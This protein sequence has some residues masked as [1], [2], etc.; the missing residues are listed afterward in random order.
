MN[1]GID[2]VG[3][4]SVNVKD[5]F[6]GTL[7]RKVMNHVIPYQWEI[8]NDRVDDAPK[9]GCMQNFKIAAG[10]AT[11]SFYG[12]V[13]Q[14]SDFA[15]WIE[16]VGYSLYIKPDKALEQ[17]ADDAIDL[18]VSAQREDG[19][20]NTYYIINGLEKRFT[21]LKDN[22]ELY[23]YGHML[24]GA[25]AYYQATGK[26]KLLGAMLRYTDCIQKHFGKGKCEGYPGHE[27][28]EMALMRLYALTHDEKHLQLAQY[29]IDQRGGSPLYLA[30]EAEHYQNGFHWDQSP[31]GYQYYQAA[32]P[33]REQTEAQGHAV[34]A[35]YLYSGMADV[36]KETGD[37]SLHKALHAL[38]DNTVYKRMY[39]TGA[40][41]SS[42]FGE[43][44]TFDYDL[45]NDT[46]YGET[47]ASIGL[48]FFAKRMLS[49][50]ADA[51]YAD[52]MERALY[53]GVVS[54]M[55]L[56]GEHFFYV[57]P[58]EV[59]PEA[60]RKD[61]MKTHVK[62]TRQKWFGCACCPPNIAR[63]MASIGAYIYMIN[64]DTLYINLYIGSEIQTSI[65]ESTV[66]FEMQSKLPWEG[67]ISLVSR[68]DVQQKVALRVPHWCDGF[69]L[70]INGET[71]PYQ[72][73]QGY[74]VIEQHWKDGMLMTLDFSMP[75]QMQMSHP[76]VRENVGKVAITRGPIVFCLEE[77]DNKSQLQ[78]IS[79]P[80][81]ACF[82]ERFQP[83]L[84]GGVL[85]L[86]TMGYRQQDYWDAQ[87]LYQPLQNNANFPTKLRFVPYYSWANR[88]ENEMMVWIRTT[89]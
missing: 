73:R 46:V 39:I 47:C 13:F 58:L 31:F 19:Y 35:M 88:G 38:W 27:V 51:S 68:C 77:M 81:K 43:S 22:H 61:Q 71:V 49:L 57:N 6:F 29:F 17:T 25:I 9:S 52:V 84:L 16:A 59:N 85:T 14:D 15:K 54:G 20:L 69:E 12:E 82:K 32:M 65:G 1:E 10:K 70:R 8:L 53:N 42:H 67:T 40:I 56:D 4:Q 89:K 2:I 60:C 34:R 3:F 76:S 30:W 37:E 86:E 44:F 75:V 18:V 83:E 55:S 28:A 62:P 64:S 7:Q 33:V 41:S 72:M 87:T 80:E 21:N 45:P 24:E 36:A 23:C 74:A 26:D 78:L 50:E 11:G 79:L 5:T 48:V 66:H 63:L